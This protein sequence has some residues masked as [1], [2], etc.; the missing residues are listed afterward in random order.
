MW[1]GARLVGGAEGAREGKNGHA[2]VEDQETLQHLQ[3]VLVRR[4]PPNLVVQ[5]LVAQRLRRLQALVR[6][7]RPAHRPCK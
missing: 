6:E 4:R 1:V 5:L 3:L 7:R 2:L